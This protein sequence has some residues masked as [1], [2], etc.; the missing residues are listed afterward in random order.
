[1]CGIVGVW[2]GLPD[3]AQVIKRSCHQLYCRGPDDS[4]TW[5]DEKTGIAIG[6]ARLAILDLSPAGH[7]PMISQC[8]RYVISFNGEI[9]NHLEIRKRLDEETS[10]IVWR[11]HSDTETLLAAFSCWGAEATLKVLVGMFAIALWDRQARVLTLARDRLGEKPLYYGWVGRTLTFASEVKAIRVIPGFTNPINRAALSLYMRHN[12]IPAPFSIYEDIYKL[13]PGNWISISE[14]DIRIN[15]LPSPVE[16]WSLL[17]VVRL[18]TIHPLEFDNDDAA[19]GGLEDV[20]SKSIRGQMLADVPL[21]AF[22]SGGIDSSTVVALMQAQSSRPVRTFSIGFFEDGFNEALHAGKVARHLGTDH[23]EMYVTERDALA[24]IPKLPTIYC[25]PFSDSSQ[26]PTFLI[27]QMTRQHV[28]VS[29]SGDAGDELFGG[30]TRYFIAKRVWELLAR[31]PKSVRTGI[32]ISVQAVPVRVWNAL[33]PILSPFFPADRRG[34]LGDRLFKSAALLRSESRAGFYRDGFVS[35]W[36]P[37]DIV[38]GSE[39][40]FTPLTK[41]WPALTTF[42]EEMMA[43]DAITYLPDDILVKVDRAAMA[44]SLETRIPFL[45]HQVVEFAWRLPISMKIRNGESK[46]ILRQVLYRYVP[47]NLIERPKMGFGVPIGAWLRGTLREWTEE[48]LDEGRLRRE[49]YFNPAPIRQKWKEHLSG[50][51]NWQYHLWDVL[52]F[53]AWLDEQ[54]NDRPEQ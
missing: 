14:D 49:G 8:G 45:D 38:L 17:D 11:G 46:W 51:R 9:Y 53:H 18:G 1:M 12:A 34:I 41:S 21:G 50:Q 47:R 26:I 24:V 19:V 10:A 31:I 33:S 3:V 15:R 27:S 52:M 32:G 23:T 13:L 28:T 44:V 37:A 4:G 48:L 7:Q 30:Y 22:L 25:E 43:I 2:G 20:L 16:Y 40:P 36:N 42:S 35:H 29:L 39:E 5:Y 6:H 54:K